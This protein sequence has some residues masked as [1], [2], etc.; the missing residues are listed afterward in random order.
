MQ[1]ERRSRVRGED[2]PKKPVVLCFWCKYI[3]LMLRM[4]TSYF[5]SELWSHISWL[6]LFGFCLSLQP[7]RQLLKEG[8]CYFVYSSK[9]FTWFIMT[10]TSAV[11]IPVS[12]V[13]LL[14]Y[15][16]LHS[17][18]YFCIFHTHFRNRNNILIF[19]SFMEVWK[20]VIIAMSLL[21]R[22]VIIFHTCWK[23]NT[24]F[25]WCQWFP[26]LLFL[27]GKGGTVSFTGLFHPK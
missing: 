27:L 24:I 3:I 19:P 14:L 18:S 7:Q 4:Y 25:T 20:F 22:T 8:Y 10:L 11:L 15:L 6:G 16:Q 26:Y 5:E 23:Q 9:A 12:A 17:L 2:G 13:F 1:G 21:F